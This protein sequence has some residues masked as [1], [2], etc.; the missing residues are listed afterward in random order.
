MAEECIN[1]PLARKKRDAAPA[2]ELAVVEAEDDAA[3]AAVAGDS[4][5]GDGGTACHGQCCTQDEGCSSCCM[6][7]RAKSGYYFMKKRAAVIDID[8]NA[9]R[10]V[11]VLLAN[12]SVAAA[13]VK[14]MLLWQRIVWTSVNRGVL[15][16]EEFRTHTKFV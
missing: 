3:Q 11:A 9:K 14:D 10:R 12:L 4:G 6:C 16:L 2:R 5:F 15:N 8:A 7:N 13:R 1:E